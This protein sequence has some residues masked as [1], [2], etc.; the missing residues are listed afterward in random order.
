MVINKKDGNR[1]LKDKFNIGDSVRVSP[2]NETGIV[3]EK[4]NSNGDVGVIVKKVKKHYN[5]K[6]VKTANS[7][8]RAIP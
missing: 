2:D 5:H 7:S 8:Q 4:I 1:L 6:R 3:F